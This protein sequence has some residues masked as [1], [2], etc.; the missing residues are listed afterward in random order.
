V[1]V[2]DYRPEGAPREVD[3]AIRRAVTKYNMPRWFY[4]ALI[5]PDTGF[6]PN[7]DTG[8]YR[9][10]TQLGP[11]A[12]A[13]RPYPQDLPFPDD[14]NRQYAWDMNF[15]QHGPWIQMSRVS[16]LTDWFD[17][18]Q[19]LDRFSTG[20]AVPAF[21]LF[22]RTYALDDVE[23]LRAVAFHWRKGVFVTYDAANADY[24]PTYDEYVRYHRFYVEPQ[25]GVWQGPP[26]MP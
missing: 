18:D 9:G 25:D 12:Y 19:N 16:R 5:Q 26:A 22:K 2:R 10:L 21:H 7:T 8:V 14:L 4:Y 13:G 24:L 23:T 20:Y 17:P 3:D 6:D 1:A 11:L 15:R